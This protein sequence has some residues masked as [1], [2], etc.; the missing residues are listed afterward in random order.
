[1]HTADNRG[2]AAPRCGTYSRRELH[3]MPFADLMALVPHDTPVW[4][5]FVA[6]YLEPATDHLVEMVRNRQALDAMTARFAPA[7][8][9]YGDHLKGS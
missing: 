4:E 2:A 6:A 7:V 9:P 3:A 5:K 8:V 1:M